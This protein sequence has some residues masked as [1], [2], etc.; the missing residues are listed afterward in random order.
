M[1]SRKV[2][3]EIIEQIKKKEKVQE[4]AIQKL[5]ET[6]KEILKDEP[7]VVRLRS[8][9]TICGDIHGQLDDLLELFKIGGYPPYANYIFLGD[10]VDRGRG[11]IETFLLLLALKVRYKNR[12]T[13]LRGNHE[14][15]LIT[16]VY[17]FYDECIKKYGS[18]NVWRAFT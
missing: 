10:Y 11:S 1:S 2:V 8:P 13:L 7:N 5:C 6:A 16:Q 3:D 18:L 4:I 14:S 9:M 17:G 15:R 12:V